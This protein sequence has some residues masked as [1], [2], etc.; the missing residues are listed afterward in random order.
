MAYR[1]T[2]VTDPH[3]AKL[4]RLVDAV[5]DG[6]GALD[7]AIRRA[8]AR[9]GEVPEALRGYLD[10]VA[11]H[12]YK[13]TD[14]DVAALRVAGYSEDQIFEATVG[15]ALGACL[16]RLDAGLQAIAGEQHAA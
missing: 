3:A 1:D 6:E 12:A 7:P 11:R 15:C 4:E 9:G 10:K 13:V 5:L 8:A 2:V 16:H 14:D